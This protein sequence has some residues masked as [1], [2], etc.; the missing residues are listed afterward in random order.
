MIDIYVSSKVSG[1]LHYYFM[2]EIC[3]IYMYIVPREGLMSSSK[4]SQNIYYILGRGDLTSS[5][6]CR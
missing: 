3:R 2:V 5:D 1:D 6:I 4:R